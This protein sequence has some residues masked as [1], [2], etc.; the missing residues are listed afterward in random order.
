MRRQISSEVTLPV[1]MSTLRKFREGSG[2]KYFGG[3]KKKIQSAI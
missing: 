2:K 1:I 3:V